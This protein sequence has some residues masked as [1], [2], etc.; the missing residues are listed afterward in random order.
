MALV[1][2]DPT[3]LLHTRDELVQFV[4]RVIQ[5]APMYAGPERRM[6]PRWLVVMPLPA[7][8]LDGRLQPCGEP[9]VAISRDVSTTGMGLF[10]SQGVPLKS[11]LAVELRTPEGE[12]MQA[13]LEV[14]HC[15]PDSGEFAI[16][17]AFLAKVYE[18]PGNQGAR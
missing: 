1:K 13:V 11:L 9:F 5:G 10:H 7:V 2:F 8:R 4:Q 14:L 12:V 18:A 17:G 15:R 16:G 3:M 6:D